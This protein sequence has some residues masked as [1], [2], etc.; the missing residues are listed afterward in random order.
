MLMMSEIIFGL[1][2]IKEYLQQ[3]NE[4]NIEAANEIKMKAIQGMN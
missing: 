3:I 2:E 1:S 4:G